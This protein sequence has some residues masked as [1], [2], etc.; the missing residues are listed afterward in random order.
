[1]HAKYSSHKVGTNIGVPTIEAYDWGLSL[2]SF[3]FG[4]TRTILRTKPHDQGRSQHGARE[5]LPP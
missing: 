1:M 4:N 3:E 5:Q 2:M